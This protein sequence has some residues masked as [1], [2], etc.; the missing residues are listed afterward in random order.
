MFGLLRF[1]FDIYV[2]V[3][4]FLKNL[5]TPSDYNIE[6]IRVIF[7][8]TPQPDEYPELPT[9]WYAWEP[10]VDE[11]EPYTSYLYHPA[12]HMHSLEDLLSTAPDYIDDIVVETTF[13]FRGQKKK[14]QSKRTCW[15]PPE[16][17]MRSPSF[18]VPI[19]SAHLVTL[20]ETENVTRKIRK[21]A[22]PFGDFYG[23]KI[24]PMDFFLTWEPEFINHFDFLEIVDVLGFK[25]QYPIE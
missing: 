13:W 25:K 6:K 10:E 20:E 21:F 4:T 3:G 23:K 15:P 12:T 18:T 8:V 22:G 2:S 24:N 7:N 16:C 17:M 1:L 5:F 14:Y 11:K 19:K 9:L